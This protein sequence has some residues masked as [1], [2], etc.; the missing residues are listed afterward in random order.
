M[1]WDR[2]TK[3][4][5]GGLGL[6]LLL[7]L[8]LVIFATTSG[9]KKTEGVVRENTCEFCG[10]P[11]P[12]SGECLSCIADMGEKAY[13]AKREKKNWYNSPVIPT[14]VIAVLC[15]LILTHI[16]IQLWFLKKRKKADVTHHM[17]CKHCGRKLRYRSS[18][19][20]RLGKCPI[21]MKP[22]VFPKPPEVV[23]EKTRTSPWV[24][25]KKIARVVWG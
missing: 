24:K 11:L 6:L 14:S 20:N 18:Q 9:T 5:V 15:V 3:L 2:T 4:A 1:K 17:H 12:K 10:K 7:V 22:I 16:S 23:K 13:H 19:I 8:G 21:C 25:I